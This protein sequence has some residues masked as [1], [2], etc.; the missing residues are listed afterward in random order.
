M[1]SGSG[2]E[3][4]ILVRHAREIASLENVTPFLWV[5]TQSTFSEETDKLTND[6]VP[7]HGLISYADRLFSACGFNMMYL[8]RNNAIPHFYIPFPRK[9]DDQFRRALIRKQEINTDR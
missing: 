1:H 7:A 8:T 9:Y 5:V 3:V 4:D 6:Q 2:E